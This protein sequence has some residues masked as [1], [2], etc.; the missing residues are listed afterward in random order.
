MTIDKSWTRCRN[1]NSFEF[2]NGLNTFLER[3]KDHLNDVSRCRCPC[4]K[5]DNKKWGTIE[6]VGSHIHRWGFSVGYK[7][8]RHHGE[9]IN[10]PVVHDI[11]QTTNEM[12]DVINDVRG[13]NTYNE[14][15]IDETSNEPTEGPSGT[16]DELDELLVSAETSN[17]RIL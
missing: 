14:Q 16:N 1:R 2:L 15:D 13:E 3:C 17:L 11:S 8:W 7:T 10:P 6:G 9:L 12:V 5:C 4:H